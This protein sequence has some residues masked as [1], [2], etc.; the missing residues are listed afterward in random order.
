MNKL[1]DCGVQG[2]VAIS[3][4]ALLPLGLVAGA[5]GLID[6]DTFGWVAIISVGGLVALAAVTEW[7]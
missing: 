5:A 2:C 3:L 7:F 6:A 1:K 4:M